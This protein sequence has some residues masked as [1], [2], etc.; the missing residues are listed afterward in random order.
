MGFQIP[1]WGLQLEK[2]EEKGEGREEREKEK[3]GRRERRKKV[4]EESFV[5]VILSKRFIKDDP[6]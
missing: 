5:F 3:G 6:Q 4:S 1:G 2:R